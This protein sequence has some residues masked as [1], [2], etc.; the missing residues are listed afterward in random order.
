MR[1]ELYAALQCMH[2]DR[3]MHACWLIHTCM[4]ID[5]CMFLLLNE[6]YAFDIKNLDRNDE[7]MNEN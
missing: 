1:K 7:I 2:V 5:A 6:A 3:C 4:L